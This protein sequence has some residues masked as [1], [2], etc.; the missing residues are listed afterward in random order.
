MRCLSHERHP[1][2]SQ[3]RTAMKRVTIEYAYTHTSLYAVIG[4]VQHLKPV[5]HPPQVGNE[6]KGNSGY[7][8]CWTEWPK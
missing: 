5:L 6:S 4:E 1:V 7:P 8:Y 2:G 3:Q